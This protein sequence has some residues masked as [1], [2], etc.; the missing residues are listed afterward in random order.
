MKKY[1]ELPSSDVLND[2]LTYDFETGELYWKVRDIK[3]FYN[4]RYCKTW[5]TRYSNK[6]AGTI[7]KNGYLN[8]H[9]FDELFYNHRIIWKIV[10]GEEP[11]YQIDHV[12]MNT[13]DNRFCNLRNSLDGQNKHNQGFRKNNT[14]GI[15]GVC[16]NKR[17]SKWF[18]QIMKDKVKYHLGYFDDINEAAKVVRSF[19]EGLHKEF[20]NHGDL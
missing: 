7:G 1:K 5:N 8:L 4:E 12:N 13:L 9:I 6:K 14:S 15:K 11:I 17:L 2:I 10:T 3:Y 16:W 19:R 18:A 20:T